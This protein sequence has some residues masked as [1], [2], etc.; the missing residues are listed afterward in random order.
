MKDE[1]RTKSELIRELKY[2]RRRNKRLEV[3]ESK[4]RQIEKILS[5]S[6]IKYRSLF[7]NS[8]DAVLLTAPDGKIYSANPAACQMYGRTEEEI[9]KAGREGLVDLQ[10][11]YL[12]ELLKRRAL[13]GNA[14]GEFYQYRKDGTRFLTEVASAVFETAEGKRTSMII[15]DTTERKKIEEEV[16]ESEARY[17]NLFENSLMGISAA[18]PDGH[19]IH[20]N[21]SYAKMFG[22][23]NT[24]QMIADVNSVGQQL[25]ANPEDRKE[26]LHILAE[27][28][29]MPPREIEVV[30]RDGTH[31]FVLVS[32]CEVR[33]SGGEL[34]YLQANHI[35]ISERKKIEEHLRKSESEYK[36]LFDNSGTGIIIIGKDG[37]YLRVNKLCAKMF[38]KKV[39]EVEGKSMFDFLPVETAQ[40]YLEENRSLIDSGGHREYE[41]TFSMA[42]EKKTFLIVDQVLHDTNGQGYALQSSSVDITERK[43][44]EEELNRFFDLVPDMV[45]IASS[46]GYFKKINRA[47]EKVVGFSQKE[48]LATRFL[49][50]IHPDDRAATMKEVERQIAGNATMN[51]INRYRVKDG[52]YR[53]LEWVAT[54]AVDKSVLFASARDIT[55]RKR[56]EEALRE[57]EERYRRLFDASPDG[58]VIIGPDGLIKNANITQGRMF[59]YDSPSD[60][61]DHHATELVAMSSRGYSE[62]I[63]QRRLNGE[64]I[65]PV[66]YELIRKDG[67]TFYGE[68]SATILRGADGTVS[69]YIC[70]THDTT[71]RKRIEEALHMASLYTRSL[72]EASLDPL[73]TVSAIGKIMDV[74]K[75]TELITGVSREQL[76]GSDF[77]DY[78]TEPEKAQEGY[79]NVF[80]DGSI[81]DYALAIR[82]KSG[83]ISDVLY[84]A[85]VFR[86]DVG[87]VQG[88]FTAARDITARK[89]AEEALRKSELRFRTLIEKAPVAISMSRNGIA[90][91]SNQ[92][93]LETFGLKGIEESIHRPMLEYFA[94]QSREESKERTRRR[95]LGLYVPAEFESIGL[96]T[97]GSQFPV[98]VVVASIHLSDGE[99]NLAFITNISA[100]KRTEEEISKSRKELH[101]LADHLQNI[102]E[103]E[104]NHLAREFHDQLGQSMTA[105]KMDLS[106]LLRTISDEK[107]EISRPYIAG[108]LISANKLIDEMSRLIWEIIADLRPQML[109]DLGL[110]S[111]LEWETEGFES[112]TGISCEFQSSAGDIQ[113]D[114]KKSIALFR[115][116]QEVLTN[117]LRHAN[118]TNV[119]SVL[120]RDDE[121]LVF[122]IKD[123][124]RGITL[125]EQLK[126]NSF[127]LIGMRERAMAL[128]G[129]LKI[130]GVAGEG[131]TI[132]VRLPL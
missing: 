27:K 6:E 52:S 20:A 109:D 36:E 61:I 55:E 35:D 115:I 96:H 57:S 124:G 39:E 5:E 99:A 130:S 120:R 65:P 118:A 40:K 28:G 37:K 4:R 84:N 58:I 76:I 50:L 102:R 68:T 60:M 104:R 53:W 72:I 98:Q 66:E 119:K 67:T 29:I 19:L 69:G 79:R 42:E 49:D 23:E 88:I 81:K 45:C 122:E 101:M 127:G 33:D 106:L 25:Y 54:P 17:R 89:Q 93:F 59:L 30:R 26:V 48:I 12:A 13:T 121:M 75:A 82:H 18:S 128:G 9:C 31:F 116:Y 15:R 11:P 8:L 87:E 24:E 10:D 97:D 114:S 74:N 90:L 34:L 131:T 44:A 112:R 56:A 3:A 125:N 43:K 14:R 100:R 7:E 73:V 22:Y 92:K 86:N 1:Y 117:I 41:D 47:W 107:Q 108:E 62:Q 126:S 71:K 105:L 94:P 38:G 78:F 110:L 111:A 77:S 132:I 85:A 46:D 64:E 51:F 32:A 63:L 21:L 2:L 103:E 16:Q 80:K 91:Y 123:N 83:Q 113:M 129:Q 70:T 95:S